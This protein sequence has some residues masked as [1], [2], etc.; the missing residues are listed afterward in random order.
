MGSFPGDG[1]VD[2]YRFTLDAE[3]NLF[4]RTSHCIEENTIQ[5]WS[6]DINALRDR[7][8]LYTISHAGGPLSLHTSDGMGGCSGDTLLEIFSGGLRQEWVALAQNNDADDNS[9]CSALVL[10]LPA[11]ELVVRVSSVPVGT[12][13]EYVLSVE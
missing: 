3:S 4:A 9:P 5:V 2:N 1:T 12:D 10:D 6:L 7:D 8:D 13:V 11:Q